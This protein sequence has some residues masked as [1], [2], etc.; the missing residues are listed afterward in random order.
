MRSIDKCKERNPT[1]NY[2]KSNGL[3]VF[4]KSNMLTCHFGGKKGYKASECFLNPASGNNKGKPN[5]ES[6]GNVVRSSKMKSLLVHAKV[7]PRKL[8]V[9][10]TRAG[11]SPNR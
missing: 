9:V 7:Q 8:V 5:Y 2:H 6:R 1:S 10:P 3:A 11:M 4:S